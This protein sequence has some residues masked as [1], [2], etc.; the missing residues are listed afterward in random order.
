[1]LVHLYV[2][3]EAL[4]RLDDGG[5]SDLFLDPRTQNQHNIQYDEG[6]SQVID[7]VAYVS[8]GGER[9][10]TCAHGFAAAHP[11]VQKAVASTQEMLAPG[12]AFAR[13]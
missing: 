13:R 1:M 6:T 12:D 3:G 9:L 11:A 10:P 4:P 2:I 8:R 7:G 5:D